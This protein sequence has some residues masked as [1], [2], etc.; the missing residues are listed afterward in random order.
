MNSFL[1]AAA[2]IFPDGID[3]LETLLSGITGDREVALLTYLTMVSSRFLNPLG[4]LILGNS[5]SGKSY[6]VKQIAKIFPDEWCE[7]V[8]MISPMVLSKLGPK[9]L[10]NKIIVM[11]ESVGKRHPDTA[12]TI[13][14]LMSE[15]VYTYWVTSADRTAEKQVIEGPICLIETSSSDVSS[16]SED[17]LNRMLLIETNHSKEQTVSIM[18]AQ[19]QKA[20]S[21]NACSDHLDELREQHKA[22][23]RSL[24]T[25]PITI[26][27][28]E[29]VIPNFQSI[30]ARRDFPKVLT[31]IQT[32]CHLRQRVKE[33][34]THN[35]APYIEADLRDY[36][37]AYP[38]LNFAFKMSANAT[39]VF[40][41]Y[42]DQVQSNC[43]PGQVFTKRE[44]ESWLGLGSTKTK[45]ILR[46]LCE[47]E[48]I[49][50]VQSAKSN[51]PARYK[52]VDAVPS[53]G[54]LFITPEE[55]AVRC[56]QNDHDHSTHGNHTDF[57]AGAS[58]GGL[59]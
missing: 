41:E 27:Y 50:V 18:K 23:L 32:I 56:G 40:R 21:P 59:H 22:F 46:D 57:S 3:I 2:T 16:H 37:L 51:R 29:L 11:D 48:F 39:A 15:G 20:A 54:D 58:L 4:L 35:G 33:V 53:R 28:A 30:T 19:A 24:T 13:R 38:L 36:E 52:L 49:T 8:S 7:I 9:Y 10:C 5:C 55:L 6:T 45:L 44:V 31:I 34:K 26:P 12:Y 25:Y 17:N 43:K 42:Y 1:D 47:N 14:I